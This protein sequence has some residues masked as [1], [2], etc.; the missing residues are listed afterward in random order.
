ATASIETLSD[1][2]INSYLADNILEFEEELL[3]ELAVDM[4]FIPETVGDEELNEF[5]DELGGDIDLEN[6]EEQIL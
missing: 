5:L 4:S 3:E 2:A 1:E 6:S